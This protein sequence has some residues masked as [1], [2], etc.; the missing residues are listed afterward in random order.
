[1]KTFFTNIQRQQNRLKISLLFKRF[2][3]FT[4]RQFDI[5]IK[6]AKFSGSCFYMNTNI[7]G[8]FLIS[9][10]VPL[11]AFL[12]KIN[13]EKLDQELLRL[14]QYSLAVLVPRFI[15]RMWNIF[16]HSL[17]GFNYRLLVIFQQAN[18]YLNEP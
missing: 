4:G 11:I 12:I 17:S 6:N 7:L 15:L 8:D 5:K 16:E 3:N 9:I 14:S 18:V 13:D 10:S 1:M 2:T